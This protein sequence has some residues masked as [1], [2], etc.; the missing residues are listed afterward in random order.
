MA[1]RP[2]EDFVRALRSADVRV[3]VAEAME[4]HEV[5]ATLGYHDRGLLKDALGLTVAKTVGEKERFSEAFDLFFTRDQFTHVDPEAVHD[6][7]Q[8]G[9]QPS[10][11]P[12][13][14][15][16]NVLADMLLSGDR[17][18][19]AA[20]MEAAGQAAGVGNVRYVT[21]VNFLARRMLEQMGISELE[22]LISAVARGDVPGG[23]QLV[24]AL[25]GQRMSLI[26]EA[27]NYVE[28][29]H[30]MFGKNAAEELRAQFLEKTP[31]ATIDRRDFNRMN[32]LIRRMARKLAAKHSH[33]SKRTRRGH[34]D[35]RR[36]LRV[37][38]AHDGVPFET[39]WKQKRIEKPKVVAICDVSRSV[40]AAAQFLLMF[41]YNL[42]EVLADLR[43]FAFSSHLAEIEDVLD[44]NDVE[45]AIPKILEKIGFM[46]TDYGR[47]LDDLKSNHADAIDRRTTVI[48]LGDARSNYRD[49]R[50]D[51]MKWLNDRSRRVVWLNPEPESF[52]GIG[53]SEMLRYRP[54]CHVAKTC[55]TIKHL[56][57]VVDEILRTSM[58]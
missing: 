11:Q 4:A 53:D 22:S 45:E 40:A 8:T 55:S 51:V 43:S 50:S 12:A 19:L 32:A 14:D 35:V 29:Q 7:D 47:A 52:W 23:D 39:I 26:A 24:G 46:S 9:K 37:N 20:A 3:S 57:R 54:Y 5:V 36:T 16:G 30:E 33:R 25:E 44:N 15:T 10:E 41:L 34:L 18:G 48:V 28:R 31:L 1:Q 38:M 42:N 56:E 17:E 6:E 2:L 27:R 13:A 58:R 49:P 21:Q